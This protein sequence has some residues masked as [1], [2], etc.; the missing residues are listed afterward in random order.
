MEDVSVGFQL[1]TLVAA[2][3]KSKNGFKE[4]ESKALRAFLAPPKRNEL[5]FTVDYNLLQ[6]VELANIK[7]NISRTIQLYS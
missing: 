4:R 1:I 6:E 7:H 5:N 3:L 2:K